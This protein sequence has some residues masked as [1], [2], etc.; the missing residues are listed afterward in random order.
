MLPLANTVTDWISA[1]AS[2]VA[3]AAATVP[4]VVGYIKKVRDR[5]TVPECGSGGPKLL[6]VRALLGAR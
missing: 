2:C 1:A 4:P 6:A 3:A 5:Q